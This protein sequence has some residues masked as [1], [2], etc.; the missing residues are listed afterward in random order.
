MISSPEKSDLVQS[1]LE[2]DAAG[3]AALF[4][5]LLRELKTVAAQ[6]E[7]AAFEPAA[8]AVSIDLDY[9]SLLSLRRFLQRPRAPGV[10]PI[11]LA[12]LGGPTTHQLKSLIEVFLAAARVPVEVYEGGYGLF[13]H[14]ILSQESG[15]DLFKPQ[16]IFLATGERD[17][18]GP[19]TPRASKEHVDSLLQSET[20]TWRRLWDVAHERWG[21]SVVQNLFEIPPWGALGHYACRCPGARETYLERLNHVLGETAP[22]HV[23]LHDLRPL[24]LEA[25]ARAWFDPRFYF[26]AKMPCAPECLVTYAHSV[27]KVVLAMVGRSRKV[28]ILDLDNTL[29]GGVIGDVGA[30]GI[31]LGQGSAPGEAFLA[32]QTYVKDLRE[33][34]ILLA[35]CSKND[36]RTAR[37]AFELRDDMILRLEDMSCFVANWND[38]ATNIQGIAGR[39][40]LGLD[41]FVFVDDNPAERAVVRRFLPEVAVPDLPPDPADYVA[42]VARHRYFETISWTTEDS[43]RAAYYAHDAE[44]RAL[45][46]D[47]PDLDTF[48]ASLDMSARLQ[49]VQASN[50]ERVTQLVNKSNQFNLTTRR[51]TSGEIKAMAGD[52][53]W[54]TLTVSL[55][56][57][58]GDNGLISVIFLKRENARFLIDTWLMSCRV[59]SRGVEQLALNRL[60]ELAGECGVRSLVGTYTPTERN[61][62]VRDHYASLGFDASGSEGES[63]I[64]SLAVDQ[65]A[66]RPCHIR[67]E[68]AID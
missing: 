20:E 65:F 41:S 4:R 3:R 9:T 27:S 46:A 15:L 25:G 39:L 2:H 62:L 5:A 61:G 29:W 63:T 17:V 8:Q 64:W 23:A 21:A 35:V 24:V 32:F 6:D 26:E 51:R 47:A 58:L 10:V 55:N 59:L 33:R 57:K 43:S 28:L 13:R 16:I 52:P 67:V 40:N 22:A 7:A 14:E 56:D 19:V 30:G 31:V 53:D 50:L 34:G 36:E 68:A 37:S 49:P 11:R 48:L 1:Y 18:A 54:R 66:P 44:R 45:A 42:A 12:I 60:V 38:K